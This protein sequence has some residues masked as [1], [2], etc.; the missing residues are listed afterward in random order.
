MQKK[1]NEEPKKCI[2]SRTTDHLK[3][4]CLKENI[5]AI[6]TKKKGILRENLKHQINCKLH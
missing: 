6:S 4:I 5:G 3:I 2:K 1:K